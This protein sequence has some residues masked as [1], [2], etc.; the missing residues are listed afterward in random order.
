L[1]FITAVFEGIGDR[2][3]SGIRADRM[4]IGRHRN[5]SRMI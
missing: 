4:P 3:G 1:P 5:P 2:L